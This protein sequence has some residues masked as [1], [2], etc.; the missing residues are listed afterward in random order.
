MIGGGILL[1]FLLPL[2]LIGLLAL[3]LIAATGSGGALMRNS[4]MHNSQAQPIST[5]PWFSSKSCPVCRRPLQADWQVCPYDGTK[6][7]ATLAV[8][9]R[10]EQL[11]Q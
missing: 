8:A 10:R 7:D 6:V 5:S 2:L 9:T 1:M 11:R 4:G 3:I